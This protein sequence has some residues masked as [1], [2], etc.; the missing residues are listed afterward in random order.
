[1][2]LGFNINGANF[3]LTPSSV[4]IL[5]DILFSHGTNLCFCIIGPKQ[6]ICLS[7]YAGEDSEFSSL[8]LIFTVGNEAK[9]RLG[10]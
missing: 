5:D 9:A 10:F 6:G 8:A 7:R 4:L 3:I 1:M 2:H